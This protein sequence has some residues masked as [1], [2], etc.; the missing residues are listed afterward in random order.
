MAIKL[1]SRRCNKVS[2]FFHRMENGFYF[3][4]LSVIIFIFLFAGFNFPLLF[5]QSPSS[6]MDYINPNLRL[7]EHLIK[8]KIDS[9]REIQGLQPLYNDS[10]C[11][12]AARDHA[13]YLMDYEEISHIQSDVPQKRSPQD[14][15]NYYGAKNYKTGENIVKIF[16]GIP[17]T[18]SVKTDPPKDI[19]LETYYEIAGFIAEAWKNSAV[20]Y[21]NIL[22]PDFNITGVSA[23]FNEDDKS[24]IS[25]QVFAGVDG[26]YKV[27]RHYGYFPYD[28]EFAF[29]EN[30]SLPGIPKDT[31]CNFD[32]PWG[33]QLHEDFIKSDFSDTIKQ[34]L[35]DCHIIYKEDEVYLYLGSYD[36]AI[37]LFSNENDGLALEILPVGM[38]DCS[39]PKGDVAISAADCPVR[40]I[41]SKPV[42]LDKLLKKNLHSITNESGM[43]YLIPFAGELPDMPADSFEVNVVL[44]KNKKIWK[45]IQTH[46]L[47]G[48]AGA[49]PVDLHIY[50]G[51][52]NWG[53]FKQKQYSNREKPSLPVSSGVSAVASKTLGE[54]S[55][56]F[57]EAKEKFHD[58]QNL[59]GK[60]FYHQLDSLQDAL[61]D[62]FLE[63]AL[64]FSEIEALPVFFQNGNNL[65]D[66]TQ[67]FAQLQYKRL[68]FKYHYLPHEMND[69]LLFE[70]LSSL[71]KFRNPSPEVL[72]NYMVLYLRHLDKPVSENITPAT[73][74]EIEDIAQ[75]V[76]GRISP[77]YTDALLLF[78]HFQ[79]LEKNLANE[80]IA[81]STVYRSL[82]FVF[83]QYAD[84]EIS[85]GLRVKLSRYF[86]LFRAY[87]FAYRILD[88]AIDQEIP[89]KEAYILS[90]K[91]YYSG[92]VQLQNPSDYYSR[93]INAASFLTDEE[94]T[95]LF[96]GPCRL[97]V[98]HLNH[99]SLRNLYC[100]KRKILKH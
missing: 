67:P 95:G 40:G 48:E 20:H 33:L 90:L 94:W 19:V 88:R 73:L 100:A 6:R 30:I 8:I 98:Q 56:L 13:E 18:Y 75:R 21:I 54:Y 47:C 76:Q 12:L 23:V 99:K 85:A 42:Y 29:A 52:N 89:D 39:W 37:S 10:V 58:G 41:I 22:M 1:L 69:T 68:I 11:F 4:T 91:L 74:R 14:R 70:A 35:K 36:R 44:I 26:T 92:M 63:G 16:I 31:G 15:V 17:F 61:F 97:N 3:C 77:C 87:G 86:I 60:F 5:A 27:H 53:K 46:H 55:L 43:R 72:Y 38:F 34:I 2:G 78:Y 64:Q 65:P 59:S 24:L 45:V 84:A 49:F 32:N 79:N 9:L 28:S 83:K 51:D 71:R 25:V 82:D 50:G 81:M 93:L 96:E 62:L 66:R 80:T 57:D 7:L